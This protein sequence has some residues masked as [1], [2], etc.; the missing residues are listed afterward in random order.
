MLTV[1]IASRAE[2]IFLSQKE[3]QILKQRILFLL[4]NLYQQGYK[5][6][7]TNAAWG[8]PLWSAELLIQ[9]KKIYPD[10][11]LHLALPHPRQAEKWQVSMKKRYMK[12]KLFADT[13]RYISRPDDP[14]SF[15]KADKFMIAQSD[16]L[17]FYGKQ[18]F[19]NYG[20]QHCSTG[21]EIYAK[22]RYTP[23]RYI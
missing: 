15:Q 6:F 1:T 21:I 18:G 23:V 9:L 19:L 7:Y 20:S 2:E 10:I 11:F 17:L 8:V 4:L 13:V 5:H 12:V 3:T 14:E 16:L 22:T